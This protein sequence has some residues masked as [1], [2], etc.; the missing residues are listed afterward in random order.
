MRIIRCLQQL[1][2]YDEVATRLQVFLDPH[3][4]AALAIEAYLLLGDCQFAPSPHSLTGEFIP[5]DNDLRGVCVVDGI[6]VESVK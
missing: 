4:L 5:G 1:Q 6:R 2:R 3:P